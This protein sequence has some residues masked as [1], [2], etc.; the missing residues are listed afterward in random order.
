MNTVGSILFVFLFL[1]RLKQGGFG[2]PLAAQSALAVFL[3]IFAH[4]ASKRASVFMR[5]LAWLSAFTPMGLQVESSKAWMGLPGLLLS[6]WAMTSLGLSFSIEPADRGLIR[7]GPYHWLRHPMYAGELL[8]CLAVW[9]VWPSAR[10]LTV[11]LIFMITL[12]IRIR[13]EEQIVAGYREYAKTTR[14]RLIPGLW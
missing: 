11:T 10:N 14:W 1:V 6:L 3:L 12:I 2:L 13:A 7:S 4:T 9:I 8:S 5:A